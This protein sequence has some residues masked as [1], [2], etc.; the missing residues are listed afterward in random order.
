M[1]VG[2]DKCS[3]ISDVSLEAVDSAVP[4]ADTFWQS[5]VCRSAHLSMILL[6]SGDLD[7]DW[8]NP[9]WANGVEF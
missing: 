2:N 9:G 7:S 6:N 1:E 8:W 4:E 3:L 5:E